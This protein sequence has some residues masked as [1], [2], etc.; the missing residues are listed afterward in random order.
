LGGGATLIEASSTYAEAPVVASSG[1]KYCVTWD[2]SDGVTL[3]IYANI[4]SG[5]A[6]GGAVIIDGDATRTC[7]L[8]AV[9]QRLTGFACLWIR[10]ANPTGDVPEDIGAAIHNGTSWGTAANLL[11]ATWEGSALD[12]RIAVNDA[13]LALA[14]WRQSNISIPAVWGRVRR[15]GTWEAPFKI[16][17]NAYSANVATN[18]TQFMAVWTDGSGNINAQR[19]DGTSMAGSSQVIDGL[20]SWPNQIQ[21][22]SDGTGYCATWQQNDGAHNSI[23]TNIHDGASWGTATAIESGSGDAS[24][25]TVASN[26]SGYCVTWFQDDGVYLSIYANLYTGSWGTEAL[27]ETASGDAYFPTV[28]SNGTGYCVTWE[29]LDGA[30]NSIFAAIHN[31]TTWGGAVAIDA[32]TNPATTPA[33]ASNGTGYAVTWQQHDG[34]QYRIYANV[35]NGTAWGGAVLV[36]L[37]ATN[38]NS[39]LVASNGTGYGLIWIQH[40]GS[41]DNVFSSR[42]DGASWTTPTALQ[43]T[44]GDADVNYKNNSVTRDG[45]HYLAVWGQVELDTAVYHIES[46][47]F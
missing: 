44:I 19:H 31:G 3:S 23:Y 38:A 30:A 18:G 20:G 14:V 43:L 16:A 28:A 35:H 47:G 45:P 33:V 5:S 42:F 8:P 6:W 9:A 26:G 37:A 2:Q 25:P 34:A 41:H 10:Y 39:P 12:A 32:G 40:E 15:N 21:I 11:T 36:E 46:C 4:Y 17:D 7:M 1:T 13:G 22:A 24:Y 29:Q 27:I